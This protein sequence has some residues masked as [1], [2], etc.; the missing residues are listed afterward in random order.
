[1]SETKT[2]RVVALEEVVDPDTYRAELLKTV[3]VCP[4]DC[5]KNEQNEAE[6]A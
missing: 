3:L 1:M 4:K 2:F 5:A 6:R